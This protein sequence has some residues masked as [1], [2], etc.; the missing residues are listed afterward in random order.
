MRNGWGRPAIAS[1]RPVLTALLEDRLY[2]R[3]SDQKIFIVKSADG[4]P[5]NLI[6]PLSLKN[7][8][9]A[10]GDSMTK[11]GTNNGLRGM[12]RETI[13]GGTTDIQLNIIAERILGLPRDPEPP[14][15]RI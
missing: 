13:G 11:I 15:A 9:C 7:A 1:V 4:D 8:G 6:D 10:S 5:L 3:N 14:A 2:Y 12:L